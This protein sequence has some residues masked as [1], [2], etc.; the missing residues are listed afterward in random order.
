MDYTGLSQA[1]SQGWA[2]AS[3]NVIHP[4]D[5]P[6]RSRLCDMEMRRR[7][8]R[9]ALLAALA[10]ATTAACSQPTSTSSNTTVD[11]LFAEWNKP[12][13]PGCSVGVSRNGTTLYERGYGIAN[14]DLA[15]AITPATVFNAASVSKQFTAMSI[16]LL[17][18]RGQLSLDDDVS[19]Y[20]PNWSEHGHRITIR[21]L[22]SHTSGLRDAFVL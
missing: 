10:L 13:S 15:V 21:H 9:S 1:E 18:H 8:R 19:K 7:R 14:L 5:L 17:A 3:T 16:L 22:L 12:D 11:R 20:I 4:D 2:R 6:A